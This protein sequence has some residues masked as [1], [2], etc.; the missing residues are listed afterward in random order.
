[1]GLLSAVRAGALV[2]AALAAVLPAAAA[3]AGPTFGLRLAWAGPAGD[4][5]AHVPLSEQVTWQVPFQADALWRFEPRA[6]LAAGAYASWG[7]AAAG[8][9]ACAD[10]AACS[11]RTVRAGAQ[12]SW[13]FHRWSAGP[14]AWAGV[15]AGWEW[16]SLRRARLDAVTRTG[17]NGPELSIQGGAAWRLGRRFALGPFALVGVG[18]YSTVSVETP[19]ESASGSIGDRAVHAWIHLGVRGTIDL[20]S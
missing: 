9:A 18:R 11:A 3:G 6:P 19:V 2:G 7:P 13:T 16:A 10:A 20:G 17:W 8:S 15:G 5:A 12:A 4:A 1:V 14:E